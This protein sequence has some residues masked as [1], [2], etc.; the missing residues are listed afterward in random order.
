MEVGFQVSTE[1][2]ESA[3]KSLNAALE[4]DEILDEAQ[5]LILNRIRTRFLAEEGPTGK[6]NPSKAAI[7][8][9]ASGGTGT[10]F[11]TGRLWHSI[12]A[13]ATA[14]GERSF[15]TDVP[16]AKH[17]QQPGL[18]GRYVFLYFTDDDITLVTSLIK[19]RI[20]AA[21]K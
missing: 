16:Y 15:Q 18:Q 4:P 9:R 19:N 2:L 7:K 1:A 3:L 8:R 17:H 11:D 12:Q 14:S 13:V 20:K 5:S 21:Q 6:W 10:M